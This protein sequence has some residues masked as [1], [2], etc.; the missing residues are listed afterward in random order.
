MKKIFIITSLLVLISFVLF[1]IP[2]ILSVFSFSGESFFKGEIWRLVT[3]SFV[4]VSL[5]HLI[6]NV[7]ALLIVTLLAYEL[8]LK[9]KQLLVCFF[10]SAAIIAFIEA[11]FFPTLVIAG[12]SLGIYAVLGSITIKGSKFIS[13]FITIP[14]IGLSIFIKYFFSAF[15]DSY[16]KQAYFHFAGFITGIAVFYL[17]MKLK[18][19]RR[20]LQWNVLK[21]E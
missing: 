2:N 8:G 19:K 16:M 11:F 21:Q 7:I 12:L 14:I 6:E 18:K 3:F 10:L 20:V 1:F 13:K 4:H 9:G 17:L 5:S 15:E